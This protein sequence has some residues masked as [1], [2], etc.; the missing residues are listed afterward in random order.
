[1][2]NLNLFDTEQSLF[3]IVKPL[4]ITSISNRLLMLKK[5]LTKSLLK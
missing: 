1:M 2:L 5:C 3:I 4:E